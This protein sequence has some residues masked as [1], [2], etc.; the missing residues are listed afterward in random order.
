MK[1]G[2]ILTFYF[3]F[4]LL[5]ESFAQQDS[6]REEIINYTNKKE[7][8]I[9]NGRRLMLDSFL[10]GDILKMK[11]V[12]DYLVSLENENYAV[13]HPF[14][15]WMVLYWT[16]DFPELLEDIRDFDSTSIIAYQHKLKPSKDMLSDKLMEQTVYSFDQILRFI[17]STELSAQKRD[18]LMLHSRFMVASE[19][20]P[21]INQDTLNYYA[22]LFLEDYPGSPY[23]EFVRH[24]IR[25]KYY[26]SDWGFG[27]EFLSG[28][29]LFTGSLNDQFRNN[30]PIGIAFDVEYKNL[31]LY[32]RDYIGFSKT[33]KD[34]YF[35]DGLWEKK[36]S[37]RV[38]LPEASLGY[39]IMDNE[40]LKIAPFSG[41]ASMDIGPTEKDLDEKPEL[42]NAGLEFTTT[43]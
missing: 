34:L 13:F 11:E 31:C 35:N 40:K 17:K 16:Q 15:Y 5:S 28:Y 10:E 37:S 14:E 30:I 43:W 39:V 23:E 24:Y 27:F 4:L 18:I 41:I 19:N 29:G 20:N 1:S 38:F 3:L 33:K 32:L 12:K 6:L 42:D 9:S 21:F 7:K 36:S 26:P 2:I 8:M 22:D 25:Y